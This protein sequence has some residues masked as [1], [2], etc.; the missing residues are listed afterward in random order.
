MKVY[1]VLAFDTYYPGSDNFEASF[2]TRE[3]AETYVESEQAKDFPYDHY[4]IVD[5]TDRL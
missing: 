5:I 3:E 1:W 4:K 2:E